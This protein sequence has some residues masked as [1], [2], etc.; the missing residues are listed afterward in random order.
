MTTIMIHRD[1]VRS[2][3]MGWMLVLTTVFIATSACTEQSVDDFYAGRPITILVGSGP[4][5][6]TDT[7]AR[8]IAGYLED[9]IP[10]QP[11]VIVKTC[12][13]AAA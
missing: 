10:G 9:H 11:T 13:A 5:G 2:K 1:S 7:S 12:R 8:I 6:V 3:T 4:G